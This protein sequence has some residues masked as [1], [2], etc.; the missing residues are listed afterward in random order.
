MHKKRLIFNKGPSILEFNSVHSYTYVH[1]ASQFH[2]LM[3]ARR[4]SLVLFAVLLLSQ[5]NNSQARPKLIV[6][7]SLDQF[8]FDYLTRFNPYFGERGFKYLMKNGANFINAEYKHAFNMTGPGHAVILTGCYGNQNGITTNNWYDQQSHKNVYCVSDSEVSIIGGVGNGRSPANLVAPTFGDELRL[9]T[10]FTSKVI[11]VSN[12]DRAAILMGGKLANAAFWMSDSSFV[13]SSYYMSEL[14]AWV[15]RFNS[16]GQVNSYFGRT[17]QQTLPDEAYAMLDED[18]APY[19]ADPGEMGRSFPH[20]IRGKDSVHVTKSYFAA[21]L[22]SPYGSQILSS[23]AKAAIEGEHL[24]SGK[25][26]DLLCIG[27]SSTDYVGHAFG[28]NS[29]EVIEMAVQTDR[30]LADFFSYLDHRIGL[31]NTII[32]LTSDHGV[33]PIPEYIHARYPHADVGRLS[34]K[35]AID[36]CTQWLDNTFGVSDIQKPWIR[37][38]VDGNIYLNREL[39]A[40]RKLNLDH[41]ADALADSLR[42]LHEIATAISRDELLT[43]SNNNPIEA[44]LKHSYYP[45]RSGEVQF[46]MKPFFYLDDSSE[47]AEHGYPYDQ[48]AHV[49]LILSGEGIGKGSY[50]I[51]SSPADIGPTLSALLGIEFPAA[52][53]GRILNEALHIP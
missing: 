4:A 43:R 52:R 8:R 15:R 14:P 24:G 49:P 42:G 46:A 40:E 33:T 17:W 5:F 18:G 25:F 37:R 26:T 22:A 50:A 30:V 23:F 39:I 53:E 11:S 45:M 7:I 28:P 35:S 34:R 41:V 20:P 27:F 51:E 29:R 16:S 2:C 47:G 36:A 10:G 19:E 32:V 1:L 12:R 6:V 3:F 48:D 44:K 13:S 21:L 9:H 38:I 31:K